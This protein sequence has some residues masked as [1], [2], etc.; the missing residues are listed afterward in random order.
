MEFWQHFLL[1]PGDV[2]V[3][4]S[5]QNLAMRSSSRES[6]LSMPSF[7]RLIYLALEVCLTLYIRYYGGIEAY[8]IVGPSSSHTVGPMRAARIFIMDLKE[9]N[10]LAKVSV[11]SLPES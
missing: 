8:D 4:I 6:P 2:L 5:V 1:W 10:L 9:L 11:V 3:R 7:Q